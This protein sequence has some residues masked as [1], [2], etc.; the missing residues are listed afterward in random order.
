MQAALTT[1]TVANRIYQYPIMDKVTDVSEA[2]VR[3]N[4]QTGRTVPV[5]EGLKRFDIAWMLNMCLHRAM[6]THRTR[7]GRWIFVDFNDK[8]VF[9][10][11]TTGVFSGFKISLFDTDSIKFN[12]GANPSE[13]PAFLEL[14]NP[15]ELNQNGYMT[16]ASFTDE[17][18]IL[19][20][21]TVT[22]VA[23]TTTVI[24]VDV[25]I[26]CDDTPVLG[27]VTADFQVKTTA[28]ATQTIVAAA[29]SATP[30]RYT[31]TGTSLATGTVQVLSS[32]LYESAVTVETVP[33]P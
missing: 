20:D 27:L 32:S 28:G 3:V 11:Q 25:K 29:V 22:Q 15:N 1:T 23:G 21:V 8:Y 9:T 13:S 2:K 7:T 33:Y 30:G 19:A 31:L 26:S 4:L 14:A 5:R 12:D 10:K 16:D 6:F 18:N 24:T 17:L